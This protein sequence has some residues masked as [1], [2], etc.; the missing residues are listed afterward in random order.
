VQYGYD[1]YG[2]LFF[3]EHFHAHARLAT[4]SAIGQGSKAA[5]VVMATAGDGA[6]AVRGL[7]PRRALQSR[8]RDQRST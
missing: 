6:G 7:W 3:A 2:E 5:A 1:A 4:L 8:W